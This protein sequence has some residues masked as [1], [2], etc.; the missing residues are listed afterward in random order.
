M[1]LL[2]Y[3]GQVIANVN[4]RRPDYVSTNSSTASMDD[5]SQTESIGSAKSQ[6][7]PE[8]LSF[9]RIINGGTCPVSLI[10]SFIECL[11]CLGGGECLHMIYGSDFLSI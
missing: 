11:R 5:L 10:N 9:D 8:A 7:I 6:G 3:L 1:G 4:Y 2:P